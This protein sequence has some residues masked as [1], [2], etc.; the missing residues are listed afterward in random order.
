MDGRVGALVYL[1]GGERGVWYG[2]LSMEPFF[3]PR[4][5]FLLS[6]DIPESQGGKGKT[7]LMTWGFLPSPP[8]P[9]PPQRPAKMGRPLFVHRTHTHKQMRIFL[10]PSWSDVS[11]VFSAAIWWQTC[12]AGASVRRS[13][14]WCDG[15]RKST[16]SCRRHRENKVCGLLQVIDGGL[17]APHE[18][19]CR[20]G[21]RT[22]QYR[23]SQT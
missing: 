9:P 8:P 10:P 7:D 17:A 1:G 18:V 5:I 15:T 12:V 3:S 23:G 2:S 21:M 13:E 20:C 16:A 19:T 6:R 14:G 22:C 11:I 4:G